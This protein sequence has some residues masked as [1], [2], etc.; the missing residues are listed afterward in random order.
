VLACVDGSDESD[1]T[2]R[3]ARSFVG[4]DCDDHRMSTH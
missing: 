1:D 3:C 4:D 2:V